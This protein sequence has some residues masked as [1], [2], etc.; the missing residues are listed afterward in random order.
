[1]PE[2]RR[3]QLIRRD[4]GRRDYQATFETMQTF[5]AERGETCHDEIWLLEHPPVFTLGRN[6]KPEHVL[7]PGDIPLVQ[8]DRGGQVTYHGPGQLVAYLLVDVKRGGFGVRQLVTAMEQAVIRVLS[9]FG[10][11]AHARP[12]AP[13]VYVDDAK[14]AA[15]G[16]R[17]KNGKS[18]HGLSLNI[19]MDLQPFTRINP[20]GYAGLQVTQIKELVKQFSYND[21][22]DRL[23]QHL[24]TELGYQEV[25][26]AEQTA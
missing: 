10:I 24:A 21:I 9:D 1:M 20:C 16:L 6:A 13:G 17:V 26:H 5:S 3:K 11:E 23:T 8:V 2:S 4:L 19:D 18:Y 14:V 22:M 7:D 12:E 15:L 25:V